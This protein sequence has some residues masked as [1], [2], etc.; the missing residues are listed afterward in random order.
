[1]LTRK[2]LEPSKKIAILKQLPTHFK[3]KREEGVGTPFPPHYTPGRDTAK[4]LSF[5]TVG[6]VHQTTEKKGLLFSYSGKRSVLKAYMIV[7]L[8]FSTLEN[9]YQLQVEHRFDLQSTTNKGC[10]QYFRIFL[11]FWCL[12]VYLYYFLEGKCLILRKQKIFG[13]QQARFF[14]VR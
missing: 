6:C 13:V 2:V 9:K 10:W 11:S 5:N 14:Q 1:V 3:A 4:I 7:A 12:H 8:L